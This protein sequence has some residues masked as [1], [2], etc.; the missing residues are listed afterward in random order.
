MNYNEILCQAVDNIVTNRLKD[1]SFDKTIVCDI[2]DDKDSANGR[3]V[4]TD[5]SIK[6]DA[7]SELTKYRNGT[8]VYVTIP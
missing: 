5:G 4:V 7:Y 1:I 6:F 3:Y 2:I 8:S